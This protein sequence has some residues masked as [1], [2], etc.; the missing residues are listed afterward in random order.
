MGALMCIFTTA[1]L[2]SQPTSWL[3]DS[4][5]TIGQDAFH[6]EIL[7]WATAIIQ[8]SGTGELLA[9]ALGW[10][11]SWAGGGGRRTV[12]VAIEPQVTA[13]LSK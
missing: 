10:T 6:A 7:R 3:A 5:A 4:R 11:M 12:G 9:R 8:G 13:A 2:F 1:Q